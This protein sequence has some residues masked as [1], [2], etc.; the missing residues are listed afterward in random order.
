MSAKLDRQTP[1][2]PVAGPAWETTD[3]PHQFIMSPDPE[4]GPPDW[5][6]DAL[7]EWHLRSHPTL[8]TLPLF[9]A[10]GERL[11]WILGWP[12]DVEAIAILS[13][14]VH[15]QDI[16]FEDALYQ[17]GGRWLALVI[18]Q[19]RVYLNAAGEQACV[20][21]PAHKMIAS[22]TGLFPRGEDTPAHKDLRGCLNIP[23]HSHWY[24]FGLTAHP[25]ALRLL[26][27][28][29]LDLD[30]FS[31]HRHWPLAP[32][33]APDDP[34]AS[35]LEVGALTVRQIDAIAKRFPLKGNLT[36]GMDTRTLL[37][38]AR[39]HAQDIEFLTLAWPGQIGQIDAHA[40]RYLGK[41]FRLRH[42]VIEPLPANPDELD[43]WQMR[44][45]LC[46]AGPVW[47]GIRTRRECTDP[48]R[49]ALPGM[50]GEVARTRYRLRD[51]TDALDAV[52]LV[53]VTSQPEHP[54]LVNAARNWLDSVRHFPDTQILDLVYLEQLKG[55]WAAPQLYGH[56]DA[57]PSIWA[58]CHRNNIERMISLPQEYKHRAEL[59]TDII[60]QLWPELL[61]IPFNR[62]F[63][64]R[65]IHESLFSWDDLVSLA[66]RVIRKLKKVLTPNR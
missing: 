38:C 62:Q 27:N 56:P 61:A 42:K 48:M 58:L 14:A 22:T 39:K 57:A 26:P 18:S 66:T 30:D 23:R 19:G 6:A 24:P 32:F 25:G 41:K 51:N 3:L 54:L 53:R 31:T 64:W 10:E 45:G 55:C 7:G 60:Q 16:E 1:A 47:R 50:L 65:R 46:I 17:L 8:P 4:Y 29:Y 37:A 35:A 9:S 44:V 40:A 28:H 15:L 34:R 21:A 63:G 49:V 12:I 11:G 59:A 43:A 52:N 2:P 36:A 5:P 33:T 20:Y 13:N